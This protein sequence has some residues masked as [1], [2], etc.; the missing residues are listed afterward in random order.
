[1]KTYEVTYPF[2]VGS[3][4]R[5]Y[6]KGETFTRTEI[7]CWFPD[8]PEAVDLTIGSLIEDGRLVE[9]PETV[10]ETAPTDSAPV[11]PGKAS[12][13]APAAA[14]PAADQPADPAPDAPIT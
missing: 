7:A 4:P 13:A 11:K 14:E 12:K 1:M 3:P 10:V 8:E 2:E 5:A 9:A 6:A